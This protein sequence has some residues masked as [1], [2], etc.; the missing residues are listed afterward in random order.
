MCCI[1]G[2]TQMLH[3]N[4]LGRR[5]QISDEKTLCAPEFCRKGWQCASWDCAKTRIDRKSTR[6]NSS[7]LGISYAVFCLKKK[8]IEDTTVNNHSKLVAD[9]RFLIHGSND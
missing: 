1:R 2:R 7:H 5:A 4:E 6:L 3:V 9:T 8:K